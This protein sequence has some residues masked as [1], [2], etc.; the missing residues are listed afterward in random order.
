[1]ATI[2]SQ[3]FTRVS[4]CSKCP[5]PA[6]MQAANINTTHKQQA[7]QHAF[8]KV[9]TVLKLGSQNYSHLGWV[10]SWRCMPKITKIGP[11]C[12]ELF[13]KLKWHVFYGPQCISTEITWQHTCNNVHCYNKKITIFQ[14]NF[15]NYI[16]LHV[17]THIK[18]STCM[19]ASKIRHHHK[20]ST[21]LV[22][23]E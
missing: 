1:L 18:H 2:V 16:Q 21:I 3:K 15:T 9:V 14:T 11:C 19:F 20:N 8:H 23:S 4:M 5:P 22:V 13:K 6:L 17:S 7:Q 12:T 10:S